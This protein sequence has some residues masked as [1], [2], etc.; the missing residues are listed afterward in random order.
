M[1]SI[2]LAL[3]ELE[4][5]LGKPERVS[6]VFE[7]ASWGVDGQP[8]YLNCVAGYSTSFKP[9]EVLETLLTTE[10]KAGRIRSG[11]LYES[12][13]I[14]LDLLLYGDLVLHETGLQVPHP[15]MTL[16]R[17]TMAPLSEIYPEIIH[18]ELKKTMAELMEE[19]IDQGR[20]TKY[21]Q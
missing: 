20:I 14:D 8:D 1:E 10:I 7:T 18:P 13:I 2:Q 17:F 3:G 4:S 19:C 6:S 16:R 21:I 12:R 9:G 11:K 5:K 15:R